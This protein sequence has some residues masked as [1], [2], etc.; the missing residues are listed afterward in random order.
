[1]AYSFQV[2]TAGLLVTKMRVDGCIASS[3]CQVLTVSEGDVLTIGGL[4]AL[5][6]AEVDNVYRVLSLIVATHQEV[7]WLDITVDN[8]FLV[9]NFDAL[10]HLDGDM[11][12]CLEVEL[13]AA[14]LE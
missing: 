10:D 11:Q 8:T 4:E 13:A 9:Y 14:L 3:A 2:I 5:G 1:M 6:E 12:D 7:V